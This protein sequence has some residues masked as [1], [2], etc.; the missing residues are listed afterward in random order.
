MAVVVCLMI[1]ALFTSCAGA[2]GEDG[3][4]YIAYT[5]AT[6]PITFYYLQD[7]AFADNS[8]I[9][10]GDYEQTVP[11]RYYFMYKSW[12]NSVW[13]GY[14]T[15]Y[16]NAGEDGKFMSDG[17]DGEDLY[18]ELYC[19]SYGPTLYVDTEPTA[20]RSAV[21]VA[22]SDAKRL[23]KELQL[24]K[25]SGLTLEQS[26]SKEAAVS[27]DDAAL[28]LKAASQPQVWDNTQTVTSGKYTIVLESRRV[29]VE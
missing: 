19:P 23:Q 18:F 12:N 5:W 25:D 3:D 28:K 7:P 6:G 8:V 11:G 13:D 14:Y 1:A 22:T 9:I 4:A 15:I 24:A 27:I 2:D 20:S 16:V 21:K 10:N 29:V 17:D 26:G